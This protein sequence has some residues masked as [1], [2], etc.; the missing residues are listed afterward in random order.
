M[1]INGIVAMDKNK[2]I[3]KNNNLPWTLNK[4]LKHFQNITTGNGNNAIIIGRNTWNSIKFLKGRDHLILSK[5]LKLN[6]SQDGKIIKSFS[7]ITE[8]LKFLDDTKYD[9][10]WVIGGS[11]IYKKF[12]E[13]SLIN[14]LYITLIN[15]SY[16]CDTHFP[17]IPE[18]YFMI[19]N[20]LLEEVTEKGK[21]TSLA[22]FKKIQEG[23]FVSHNYNV[24]KVIKIHYD[25][26]P[27]FYFTI[28]DKHGNEKQTVNSKMELKMDANFTN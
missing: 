24:Y 6:Y 16:D 15:D 5:T 18:N 9:K 21:H 25:D 14:E 4:D 3:G 8:L 2:G 27:H 7:D 17:N 23:M 26:A 20:K 1:L 11:Q 28:V 12:L 19:Q 10:I 22:I 13:L